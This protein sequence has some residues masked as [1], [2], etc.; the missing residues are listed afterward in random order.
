MTLTCGPTSSSWISSCP[1]GTDARCWRDAARPGAAGHPR[2]HPHRTNA[3][4]AELEALNPDAFL[5]KPVDFERLAQA[6]RDR[7]Q[8]GV[9][10]RKAACLD[11]I[12]LARALGTTSGDVNP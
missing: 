4:H 12:Q 10:D 5:T 7:R 9:H 8:P 2:Y 6:G 11:S 3:E 1:S